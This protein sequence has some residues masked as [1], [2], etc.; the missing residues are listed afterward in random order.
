MSPPLLA[1]KHPSAHDN[2]IGAEE[3]SDGVVTWR[4]GAFEN[5]RVFACQK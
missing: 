2:R 4:A 5:E 1:K 3:P